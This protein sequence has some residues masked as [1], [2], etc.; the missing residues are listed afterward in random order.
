MHDQ[1]A[2]KAVKSVAL[3]AQ[4]LQIPRN[5]K[6]ARDVR[7]RGVECRVEARHLR[8]PGKVLLSKADDR[9]RGRGMQRRKSDRGYQLLHDRFV[10]Q[11]VLPQFWSAMHNTMPDRDRC[12]PPGI[13]EEPCDP[14]K[15]ILLVRNVRRCLQVSMLPCESLPETFRSRRRSPPLYLKAVPRSEGR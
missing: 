7:H 6:Y 5:R 3:Y 1:F 14:D 4:R 10:D 9:Q 15:R 8:K 12:W 2:G 11:A 13:V